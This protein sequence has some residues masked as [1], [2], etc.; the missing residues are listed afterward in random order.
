VASGEA[1]VETFV[2]A[3]AANRPFDVVL[4]DVQMPGMGGIAAAERI[5]T[6]EADGVRTRLLALTANVTA[7]DRDAC[8]A[9]GMDGFLTKPVDRERLLEAL[10]SPATLAA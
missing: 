8:I 9:A 3:R 4:M 10:S 5:R 7:Q 1:A 6:L 2:A